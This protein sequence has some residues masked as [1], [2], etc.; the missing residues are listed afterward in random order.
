M[1]IQPIRSEDEARKL[2]DTNFIVSKRFDRFAIG[3]KN[4][5]T[6]Q[7]HFFSAAAANLGIEALGR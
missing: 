2:P 3:H 4:L 1:K 5:V 6:R 7:Q